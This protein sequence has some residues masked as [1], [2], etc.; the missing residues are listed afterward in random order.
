MRHS[1]LRGHL[2]V[3]GSPCGGVYHLTLLAQYAADIGP[4]AMFAAC[5]AWNDLRLAAYDADSPAFAGEPLT[6]CC[7][8]LI[9]LILSP[10]R[11]TT[12]CDLVGWLG[13]RLGLLY[14]VTPALVSRESLG[15]AT[16]LF[17]LLY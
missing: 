15:L 2:V 17:F 8:N 13:V 14:P 12:I 6:P 1:P 11:A 5:R 16:F 9:V 10:L 4:L 7:P 3:Y